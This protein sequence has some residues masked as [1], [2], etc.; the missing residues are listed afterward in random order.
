M[1]LDTGATY[2]ALAHAALL[3]KLSPVEH[4]EQL[5]LLAQRLPLELEPLKDGSLRVV[6]EGVDIS[7]EIRT[8]TVSEAAAQLSQHATVRQAMVELQRRLANPHGVVVEG[9]DTGSVVFPQATFKFFLDANPEIR[10]QRR[11]RELERSYGMPV[12]LVMVQGQLQ[13]R[14]ALDRNRRVGPL[15]RPTGAIEIDTSHLTTEQVVQQMLDHMH[16]H[17]SITPVTP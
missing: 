16:R 15:I 4:A 11:Q 3:R 17:R 2:R 1:Y 10:A 13:L 6:L 5:T 14:D 12:P 7:K 9:R 8:E